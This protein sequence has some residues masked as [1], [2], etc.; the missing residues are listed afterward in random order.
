MQCF[1][2]LHFYFFETFSGCYW[3]PA[4]LLQIFQKGNKS[5]TD[6]L[7]SINKLKIEHVGYKE[8]KSR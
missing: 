8:I 7:F 1:I 2:F 6:F 5:E 4:V 3:S